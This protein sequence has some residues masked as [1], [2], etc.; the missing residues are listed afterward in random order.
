MKKSLLLI[1]LF[2][3]SLQLVQAQEDIFGLD[4]KA[5]EKGKKSKSGLGN[6]T[7]NAVSLLS[8]EVSGGGAYQFNDMMF[9][10]EVPSRYPV[11]QYQFLE[12]PQGITSED[13]VNLYSNG[14]AFPVNAGVRINLFNTLTIGGGYAREFGSIGPMQGG[15]FQLPFEQRSY[16]FDKAYGSLGLVLYDSRKRAKFLSWQYKKFAAENYAMQSELKQRV[17]FDYPWRFLLEG[18]FGN[19]YIRNG[20]DPN[21]VSSDQP[22]YSINLRVE[23]EFSEYAKLFVKTGMET[24]TFN[25]LSAEALEFKELKQRLFGVQV[26][27]SI[28]MPGTKRCKHRGCAVVMKHLHDGV[29]YRGSSIFN[30]QNRKVGQWY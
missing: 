27:L 30:L 13:T 20:F 25:Y 17:R 16:T 23:K 9:R 11:S 7:R 12:Q 10:S 15:V 19:V 2:L 18:D 4:T 5:R 8:F 24:R 6:F 22:F 1:P 28:N 29:E 14:T 3:V 21:V 26:G